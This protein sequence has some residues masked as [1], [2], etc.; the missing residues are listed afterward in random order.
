MPGVGRRVGDK[1]GI[2][3]GHKDGYSV[4]ASDEVGNIV[5]FGVGGVPITV[6]TNSTY[7]AKVTLNPPPVQKEPTSVDVSYTK[8]NVPL[9]VI[10]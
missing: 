8:V 6:R 9:E 5:G 10:Y 1:D 4:G 3:V 7:A 2:S